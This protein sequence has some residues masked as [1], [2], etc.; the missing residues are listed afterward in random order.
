M[1]RPILPMPHIGFRWYTMTLLAVTMLMVVAGLAV[2][3][4]TADA[5]SPSEQRKFKTQ[6]Q[7]KF[8][9][10]ALAS[11]VQVPAGAG[12]G[13]TIFVAHKCDFSFFTVGLGQ[14]RSTGAGRRWLYL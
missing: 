3:T 12:F 4:D 13:E 11:G 5:A 14:R 6:F 7:G 8:D 1:S 2:T 9:T 10:P